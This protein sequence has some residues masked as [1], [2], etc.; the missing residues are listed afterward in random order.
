MSPYENHS[1]YGS[2][3]EKGGGR[4]R[5]RNGYGRGDD[6]LPRYADERY[7]ED[8]DADAN[9]YWAQRTQY[10]NYHLGKRM[11][12]LYK[13][14]EAQQLTQSLSRV[15]IR[16]TARQVGGMSVLMHEYGSSTLEMGDMVRRI[17]E[18]MGRFVGVR[19]VDNG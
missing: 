19:R 16:R 9:K 15:Q 8:E 3:T 13:K 4:A 12:W 6:Q 10:A 17:D 11:K 2:P 14:A 5:S 7:D 1:A 18:R